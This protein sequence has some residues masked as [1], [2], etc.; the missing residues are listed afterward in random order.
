ML[1]G[2]VIVL[3]AHRLYK[4]HYSAVYI[5]YVLGVNVIV[6][7]PSVVTRSYYNYV[8]VT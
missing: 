4:L 7:Q 2:Y 6:L 1:G 5:C 3:Q 8:A